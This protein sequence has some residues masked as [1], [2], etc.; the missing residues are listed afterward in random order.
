M[1]AARTRRLA[2]ATAVGAALAV[3]R[4]RAAE[5]AAGHPTARLVYVR[6]LAL[7]SCPDEA[8]VRNA[9]ASRL[10]YDPFVD[11]GPRTVT[12][13]ILA[14]GRG[15]RYEV[16]L[17]DGA[18][19]QR[20][21]KRELSTPGGDCGELAS[22][23]ELAI[24]IAIDPMV[25]TR[26]APAPPPPT[27]QPQPQPPA[28]P[29]PPAVAPPAVAV[30]TRPPTPA[31]LETGV[32]VQ[33]AVGSAPGPA[34]GLSAWAGVRWPRA[35]LSIEGRADF[36]GGAAQSAAGGPGRVEAS[37]LLGGV[38]PCVH[39]GAVLAC[40]I[41]AAGALQGTGVGVAEPRKE[42][43]LYVAAGARLG[44]RV[45]VA[46]PLS[47]GAH[48]DL[49]GTPTRTALRIDDRDVWTT[50]PLSAALGVGFFGTFL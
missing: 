31:S 22:A 44:A 28:P 32:G 26:A 50:P 24:S 13:R 6:P 39:R 5:A 9:V 3:P 12:A 7:D 47:V 34:V 25:A 2:L 10:G 17:L 27:P 1:I 21:G 11:D 19:A 14:S 33:A 18:A 8:A 36:A 35:S 4:A 48:L 46:G 20:G 23:M 41:I 42:T 49:L 40:A 38:V 45:R 15:L 29:P 37:L 43:T 30:A 16:A